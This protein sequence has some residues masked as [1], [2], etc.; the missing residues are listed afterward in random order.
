MTARLGSDDDVQKAMGDPDRDVSLLTFEMSGPTGLSA[1]YK[2]DNGDWV[3]WGPASVEV[4]DRENDRI[5]AKALEEALPQLLRRSSLSYEHTDQIVGEI[6]KSYTADEEVELEIQG[7]TYK[8]K[9][10]PTGVLDLPGM[11]PAMYVAGKV[12]GAMRFQLATS[13][14]T[15]FSSAS[16]PRYSPHSHTAMKVSTGLPSGFTPMGPAPRKDTGRM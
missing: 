9:E 1:L 16:S 6:L 13:T 4:V 8:R 12:F 7:N 3:I 5:K 11:E 10:F 2:A 14:S 15:P